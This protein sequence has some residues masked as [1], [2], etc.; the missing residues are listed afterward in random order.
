MVTGTVSASVFS[1]NGSALTNL[2]AVN[3]AN[4]ALDVAVAVSTNTSSASLSSSDRAIFSNAT[5]GNITLTLPNVSGVSGRTVYVV[6]TD[7]SSNRVIIDGNGA[8]IEGYSTYEL[9][10]YNDSV[11]LISNGTNWWVKGD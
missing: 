10:A 4:L 3:T 5:A 6:K 2:P 7:A 11:T 8:T 1:G 9:W